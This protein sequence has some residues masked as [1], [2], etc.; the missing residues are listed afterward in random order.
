MTTHS[1]STFWMRPRSWLGNGA[2]ILMVAYMVVSVVTIL[3]IYELLL[4]YHLSPSR[5]LKEI[6]EFFFNIILLL[7]AE[8]A[9]GLV[10]GNL[11]LF[12]II[13]KHERS[14]IVWLTL[15]LFV[16]APIYMFLLFAVMWLIFYVPYL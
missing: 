14:W 1:G 13:W 11:G 4:P 12:A 15:L 10:S 8:T 5:Y 7:A 16:F 3:G 9:T 2:V 6:D